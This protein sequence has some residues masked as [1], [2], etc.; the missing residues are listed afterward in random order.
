[1]ELRTQPAERP[2]VC[3]G[4]LDARVYRGAI[5]LDLG[6]KSS[7]WMQ[8]RD[9]SERSGVCWQDSIQQGSDIGKSEHIHGRMGQRGLE[10]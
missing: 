5:A 10:R 6:L 2:G 7:Q 8:Q 3:N 1:M 4:R 9:R